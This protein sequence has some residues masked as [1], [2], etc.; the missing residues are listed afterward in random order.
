MQRRKVDFPDPDGPSMHMTLAGATSREIP[1]STSK[2]P[3]RLW[4]LS[5]FTIASLIGG[6]RGA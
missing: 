5:A 3:N 4:T 6:P 2:R 1:F